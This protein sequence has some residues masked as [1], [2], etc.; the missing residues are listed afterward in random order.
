M[1]RWQDR[2]LSF[3]GRDI[4]LTG[5]EGF[6]VEVLIEARHRTVS[7]AQISQHIWSGEPPEFEART[8][9]TFVSFVRTAI[10]SAGYEDEAIKTV[11]GQGYIW[12]PAVDAVKTALFVP[13]RAVGTLRRLLESHPDQ[14][15]AGWVIAEIFA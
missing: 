1:F 9:R 10:R 5:H 12:I 13:A 8:I 4:P 3:Q 15:S 11:R 2:R 6:L 7:I 14:R